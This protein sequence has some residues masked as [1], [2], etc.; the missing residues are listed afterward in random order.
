MISPEPASLYLPAE[1]DQVDRLVKQ[2]FTLLE[3]PKEFRASAKATYKKRFS[4]YSAT[5]YRV[6]LKES[7]L[8]TA[9][10]R[11]AEARVEIQLVSLLMHASSEVEHDLVYRPFEGT[12]S[13]EEY[14]ILD[15]LNGLV[16]AGEIALL[17]LQKAGEARV[18]GSER[19]LET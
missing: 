19:Q 10:R 11:Y 9:Q 13:D 3:P 12:H 17:R 16:I 15:E 7:S 6:Q 1:L 14:A 18:T 4:G 8:G 2:L 5:H